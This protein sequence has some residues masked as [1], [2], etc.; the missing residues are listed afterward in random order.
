MVVWSVGSA[1][2]VPGFQPLLLLPVTLRKLVNFLCLRFFICKMAVIVVRASQ[3]RCGVEEDLVLIC[4][5]V[6]L[7]RLEQRPRVAAQLTLTTGVEKCRCLL[8][9]ENICLERS[10]LY[11]DA[12]GHRGRCVPLRF[13]FFSK[14]EMYTWPSHS[15][16]C[17]NDRVLQ[18]MAPKGTHLRA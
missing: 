8:L 18:R 3:H 14:A 1:V 5:S 2:P 12:P 15:C 9:G 16:N 11:I 13:L 7:L 17:L 10:F 6:M 4:G